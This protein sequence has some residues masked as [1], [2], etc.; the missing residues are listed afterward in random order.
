MAVGDLLGSGTISGGP[1]GDDDDDRQNQE[2]STA[3]AAAAAAAEVVAV[4]NK[5]SLLEM[6]DNGKK[7]IKIWGSK[8]TMEERTFLE[9]GDTV[10][11]RGWCGGDNDADDADD[12]DVSYNMVGFG[13]CIGTIEPALDL[14]LNLDLGV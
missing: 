5:G 12:D 7:S 1:D 8:S 13:E 3:A 11:L 4:G 14:D 10:I 2:K 6:T 9:D